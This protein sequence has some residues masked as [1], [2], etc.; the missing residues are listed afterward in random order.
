MV[1]VLNGI[2]IIIFVLMSMITKSISSDISTILRNQQL[3]VFDIGIF[4]LQEDMKSAIPQVQKHFPDKEIEISD[5]YTDV[6]SSLWRNTIDLIVSV[7]MS[8]T[9]TKTNYFSD[10]YR[11]KNIFFSVRDHLLRN[12]NESNYNFSRASSYVVSTFSTPTSWP[13]WKYEQK[14]IK[15]L[16]SMI[17]LEVTL[18]PSNEL[19]FREGVSPINCKGSLADDFDTIV[20]TKNFN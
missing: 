8:E 17:Q 20:V 3:T 7:P 4:R 14:K 19:A 15:E 11:C 12:Q 6:V 13:S 2:L 18:R 16:V 10:M 5:V 1:K 9:L